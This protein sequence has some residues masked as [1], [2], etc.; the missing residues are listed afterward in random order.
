[1]GQRRAKEEKNPSNPR[2]GHPL[3]SQGHTHVDHA[4]YTDAGCIK[5]KI[6]KFHLHN[7]LILIFLFMS[8]VSF[9]SM[10]YFGGLSE[11]TWA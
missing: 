5:G 3:P 9:I 8:Y 6:I 2:P 10:I 11:K 4:K 7:N 1:L